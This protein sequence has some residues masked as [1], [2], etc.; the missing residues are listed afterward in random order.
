M[1][2]KDLPEFVDPN[3]YPDFWE[4]MKGFAQF[5]NKQIKEVKKPIGNGIFIDEETKNN[6][7]EICNSCDFFDKSQK[8]CRKC[9][10]FMNIKAQFRNV[11]CPIKLW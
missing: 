11:Q 10:C 8:R 9:G 5:T 2:N 3:L 1:E 6:R 4:Q 7:L